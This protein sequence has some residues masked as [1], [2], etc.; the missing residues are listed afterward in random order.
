MGIEKAVGDGII[1][2]KY[3]VQRVPRLGTIIFRVANECV[4]VS[5]SN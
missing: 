1:S 4:R 5:L 2:E 3:V